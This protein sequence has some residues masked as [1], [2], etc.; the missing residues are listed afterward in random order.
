MNDIYLELLTTLNYL[1][2]EKENS[3]WYKNVEESIK[4]YNKNKDIN[5]FLETFSGRGFS[6]EP[7]QS[8]MTDI[9]MSLTYDIAFKFKKNEE[10]NFIE[11]LFKN[12]IY[13]TTN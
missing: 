1:L 6:D 10:Y 12:M 4:K 8:R 2:N 3:W 9:I 13:I 11:L 7:L 5:F